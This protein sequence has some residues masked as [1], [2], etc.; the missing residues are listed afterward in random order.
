MITLAFLDIL[1]ESLEDQLF[2]PSQAHNIKDAKR[3]YFGETLS[4]EILPNPN[5]ADYKT[6]SVLGTGLQFSL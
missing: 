2:Y 1:E 6:V 5:L 4:P 3:G